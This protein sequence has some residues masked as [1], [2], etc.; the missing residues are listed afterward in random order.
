MTWTWR[1]TPDDLKDA[2]PAEA[3]PSRSEAE[4]WLGEAWHR[5][6]E[7]GVLAVTLVH[8]GKPVEPPMSLAE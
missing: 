1:Y 3:Y 7:H 5:L 2:P 8:D 6:A 4:S